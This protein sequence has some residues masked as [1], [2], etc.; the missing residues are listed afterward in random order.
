MK[1]TIPP[2]SKLILTT[3]TL[4]LSML[5][6]AS[7][8]VGGEMSYSCLG[9]DYYKLTLR[10]YRD[11]SGVVMPAS[12]DIKVA[13]PSGAVL[14]TITVSKG[15][16]SFLSINQQPCGQ[17]APNICIETA[18][19][20]ADSIYLP[21]GPSFYV[22]YAQEC[23][24]NNGVDNIANAWSVGATFPAYLYPGVA[25]GCNN[26][27]DFGAYP[28]VAIPA[29]VPMNV[30]INATDNDGDS[31]FFQLCSPLA[32]SATTFPFATVPFAAGYSSSNMVQANPGLSIDPKTGVLSG[33]PTQIGTYAIGICVN[34]YRNG[35]LIGK[36]RRDYQFRVVTPWALFA[37][38]TAKTD[39]SCG[40]TGSATVTAAGVSGPYTYSWSHGPTTASVNNL[41]AG[42]YTVVAS[43]GTCSDTATVTINGGAS[44]TTTVV[45]QTDLP[46]GSTTGA[47]AT[48]SVNGGTAPY[49]VVWPSGLGGMTNNQLNLGVNKVAVSDANGCT[50]TISINIVQAAQGVQIAI[51]SVKATSCT[52]V[53]NGFA[54]ISLLGGNAPYTIAWSDQSTSMSRNNLSAGAY[55]VK[56]VDANG[57]MDSVSVVVPAGIGFILALDSIRDVS[58]HG[59][60]DGYLRAVVFGG[61]A[62]YTYAW[63]N[64]GNGAIASGLPVGNYVLTV[65]DA[66]GCVESISQEIKEPDS[67][68]IDLLS[69]KNLSCINSLDGAVSISVTGGVSPYSVLWNTNDTG[70]VLNNLGAGVYTATVT[71]TRGCSSSKS[72]TVT[73][74]DSL[75][76]ILDVIQNVS[77]NGGNDGLIKITV[78]GGT[79]PY[80]YSWSNGE[81]TSLVTGL[82][83]GVYGLTVLDDNDCSVAVQYTITEP[84]AIQIVLDTV[85]SASC[86]APNGMASVHASG[87]TGAINFLWSN[88][89]LGGA[90][91]GLVPGVYTV[92]ATD[93]VGCSDS[94]QVTVPGGG[95]GFKARL[96]S[97][98][99]TFCGQNNGYARVE[100]MGGGAP[101]SYSWS[102][103]STSDTAMGLSA[104]MHYVIVMDSWGCK[105]SLDFVI[106][107]LS[108]LQLTLDSLKDPS[109]YGTSDG[110]LSVSISG[111]NAP[112]NIL[113]STSDTVS[114]LNNLGS[115]SYGVTVTDSRGCSSTSHFTL[116]DPDSIKISLISK[117]DVL[118]F[119]DSTGGVQV[120]VSGGHAP[121]SYTWSNGQHTSTLTNA[122]AGN[123]T[124][125]VSDSFGCSNQKIFVINEPQPVIA[126]IDKVV[127]ESCGMQNGEIQISVSGGVFPYSVAWNNGFSGL[128]INGLQAGTYIAVITDANGCTDTLSVNVSGSA[129]IQVSVDSVYD[130]ICPDDRA[131]AKVSV[132]GGVAPY[133]YI[134][135]NGSTSDTALSLAVGMNYVKVLDASGCSD[136]VVLNISIPD[137]IKIDLARLEDAQCYGLH[138][139]IEIA[140][141]GG[142]GPYHIEWSNQD[143]GVVLNY[144]PAGNY[145]VNVTDSRGCSASATYLISQPD[146]FGVAIDS[147][148]QPSCFGENDGEVFISA[149]GN[150]HIASIQSNKGKVGGNGLSELSAG[151]YSVWVQDSVGCG[152][153]V[154]FEIED[155][156]PLVV[157]DLNVVPPGCNPTDLGFIELEVLGGVAPYAFQWSDGNTS[158]NR[159]D[160]KEGSYYLQVTDAAGC[161]TTRSFEFTGKDIELDLDIKT[162]ACGSY[163]DAEMEISVSGASRPFKLLLNGE[164]VYEGVVSLQSDEYIL[165]LTDA[166]GCTIYNQFIIDEE[167][168][169]KIFFANAFTPDRDGYN[170][171]YKIDGNDECFTN[172]HLEI[173]SRW[174]AKVFETNNPFEEFWDGKV[175]GANPKSDVYVYIFTSDQHKESGSLKIL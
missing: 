36:A 63:N 18:D 77:C 106:Y 101:Y 40:S 54:S 95:A 83:A 97:I 31:L 73:E 109:C 17:P 139:N 10:Y 116:T 13:N 80:S 60:S 5:T 135:S 53:N 65:T 170:D 102:N 114:T 112:Y 30:P 81:S 146:S 6:Y 99:S 75:E 149:W 163:A 105:D 8:I 33:T 27:P 76:V 108:Q 72:F 44:F 169:R 23:C 107:S 24:R 127:M 118:C 43:N 52:G 166:E 167:G 56:V 172:A 148:K 7:H 141:S 164:E 161:S 57:C 157:Q 104:G 136:S 138:G 140:V 111:G 98:S 9:N 74:P 133:T 28:P 137:S 131:F 38:I 78:H 66:L 158:L 100:A 113:W 67:L 125:T 86:S 90:V 45:S 155:P 21:N 64:N 132:V 171:F 165:V 19:Y 154:T 130:P 122:T 126:T 110:Y 115:G 87:G 58:C 22:V 124:L 61:T 175:N 47:S 160:I 84:L 29:N 119:G 1:G 25:S 62:P 145:A 156:Q 159:F 117:Q 20:V 173:H 168:E 34:E 134:W 129:S 71:D 142:V 14:Q 144:A 151:T 32:S 59:G 93:S 48:I 41:A 49:T 85:V 96:D 89:F 16:T 147:I 79:G 143:T 39:A 94:L 91:S 4:L 103:G 2:C 121:Y 12:A 50:D 88:S 35:V 26:S 120:S 152:V 70:S 128:S 11:C 150:G 15:T 46:C 37:T 153:N 82:S 68:K 174:G 92:I 3:L 123:Y 51:D 162:L 42:T 69:I 55:G